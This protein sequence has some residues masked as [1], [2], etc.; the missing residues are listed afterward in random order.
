MLFTTK[1]RSAFTAVAAM[2]HSSISTSGNI[3]SD[4]GIAIAIVFAVVD[5]WLLEKRVVMR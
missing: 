1:T 5:F 2:P 4:F 3:Q